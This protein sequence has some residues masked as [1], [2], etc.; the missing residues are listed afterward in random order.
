MERYAGPVEK[1]ERREGVSL[2][3]KASGSYSARL[4]WNAG[5]RSRDSQAIRRA[6]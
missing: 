4:R 3:L 2:G 5:S 1:L 6:G